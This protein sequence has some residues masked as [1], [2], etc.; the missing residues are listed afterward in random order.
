MSNRYLE[1]VL[2]FQMSGRYLRKN[3]QKEDFNF[4]FAQFFIIHIFIY[5]L[6][7]NYYIYKLF[8][9]YYIYKLLWS[10]KLVEGIIG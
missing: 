8:I 10:M 2:I 9:N 7:T 5:K 6:F 1:D 4:I 3:F